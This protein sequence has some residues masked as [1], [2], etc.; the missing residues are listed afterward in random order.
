VDQ[1]A[2]VRTIFDDRRMRFEAVQRDVLARAGEE[3]REL[4]AEIRKVLT[5]EQQQR[6]DQWLQE[7]PRG[8]RGRGF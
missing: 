8:R 4:Q 5:P 7:Q 3:Q 1:K 6:F 2:R